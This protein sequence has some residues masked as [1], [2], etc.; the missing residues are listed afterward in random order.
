[1]GA[2]QPEHQKLTFEGVDTNILARVRSFLF[3]AG[4]DIVSI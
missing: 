4:F 1:M 2:I 3:K